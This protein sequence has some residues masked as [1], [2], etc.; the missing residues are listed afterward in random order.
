M[1]FT[2]NN[3]HFFKPLTGKYREV[4][5]ECLKQLYQSLYSTQADYGNALGR[6]QLQDVFQEALA[7]APVLDDDENGETE[8]R[9]FRGQRE[10]A[11]WIINQLIEYGWLERQVDEATLQSHYA[12]TASGRAFTQPFVE[13]G[14]ERIRTR[15]RHTRNTRNSVHSFL[16]RGEIHDLMDAYDHSE[17]IISDFTDVIAELDLKKRELVKAVE[18]EVLVDKASDAFFDFM[19]KRFQ[20]DVAVRLSADSVEKYRDEI[21]S[22]ILSIKRKRK[23]FKADAERELRKSLP[24][25]LVPDGRSYLYYLL[26]GIEG[27]L[28]NACE[29]MLPA[30][31]KALQGFT[32]RADIIL[33][34]MSFLAQR[35]DSNNATALCQQ[36]GGLDAGVQKRVFEQ[37]GRLVAGVSVGYVDPAQVKLIERKGATIVH[38][39]V[40]EQGSIDV[41]SRRALYVQQCLEKAFMV[42]DSAILDYIVDSLGSGKIISTRHLDPKTAD[43]LINAAHAIEAA[44]ASNS[45]EFMFKI[46]QTGKTISNHYLRQADEFELE[47]IN[48]N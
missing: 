26:E 18:N 36:I 20:P 44:S 29:I 2:S 27:R 9:R 3:P 38:S 19:E 33:R 7:R 47:L 11:S 31:R 23:E 32:Q 48:H 41:E 13:A 30:L 4:F 25:N 17:R 45:S 43:E 15:N 24:V 28:K 46:T 14:K 22:I 34:Q 6:A 39:H 5:V 1:F 40:A 35:D 42:N 21:M 37:I 8:N 10:Q 12:F 16:E